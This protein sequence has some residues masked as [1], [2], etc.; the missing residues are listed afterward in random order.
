MDV[1]H[2]SFHACCHTRVD[3]AWVDL[4]VPGG[5]IKLPTVPWARYDATV[6]VTL[7][8]G[9]SLV[10]ADSVQHMKRSVHVVNGQDAIRDDHLDRCA[11]RQRID[12]DQGMPV[13]HE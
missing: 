10:G 4:L 8:Q 13:R 1:N 11:G 5:D 3:D 6:Q 2:V 12:G 7:P 9:A